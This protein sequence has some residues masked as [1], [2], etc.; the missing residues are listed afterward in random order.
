VTTPRRPATVGAC[1]MSSFPR[2]KSSR[3]PH[4]DAPY[5]EGR[6][7]FVPWPAC[8]VFSFRVMVSSPP[9]VPSPLVSFLPFSPQLLPLADAVVAPLSTMCASRAARALAAAQTPPTGQ[10]WA[11]LVDDAAPPASPPSPSPVPDRRGDET[12][13]L[14]PECR[15]HLPRAFFNGFNGDLAGTGEGGDAEAGWRGAGAEGMGGLAILEARSR[16]DNAAAVAAV[17]ATCCLVPCV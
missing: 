16:R 10:L 3:L 5:P 7:L 4:A 2:T 6:E 15:A 8:L 13:I 1:G 12:P 14:T 9:L 17:C 11:L